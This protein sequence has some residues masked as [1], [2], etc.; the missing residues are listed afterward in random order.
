LDMAHLLGQL[1]TGQWN[2]LRGC[3]RRRASGRGQVPGQHG[4][5]TGRSHTGGC[6]R[7]S[8][9]MKINGSQCT[10]GCVMTTSSS[11]RNRATCDVRSGVWRPAGTK[12]PSLRLAFWPEHISLA[13]GRLDALMRWGT[14]AG[15]TAC[16]GHR[17]TSTRA[18]PPARL[19]AGG[20]GNPTADLDRRVRIAACSAQ[21]GGFRLCKADMPPSVRLMPGLPQA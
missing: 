12:V 20:S 19:L 3:A 6:Q 5:R 13:A 9:T 8:P 18:I 11:R 14:G 4:G 10:T 21:P 2:I 16:Q 15:R 17:L 7:G 1:T